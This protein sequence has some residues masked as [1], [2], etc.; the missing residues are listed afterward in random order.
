MQWELIKYGGGLG[1]MIPNE[2]HRR[3][4]LSGQRLKGLL[5]ECRYGCQVYE[6]PFLL[7]NL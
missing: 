5:N 1:G 2:V 6:R 3:Y 7:T 4:Q